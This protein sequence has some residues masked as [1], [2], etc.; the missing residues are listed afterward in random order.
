MRFY[1]DTRRDGAIACIVITIFCW[2]SL[3]IA[4][5]TVQH[6]PELM[7]ASGARY[8]PFYLFRD[9]D[10]QKVFVEEIDFSSSGAQSSGGAT[11]D[12]AVETT[13][14]ATSQSES[15]QPS[16]SSAINESARR[17]NAPTAPNSDVAST[18]SE[19]TQ[20][21]TVRTQRRSPISFDPRIRGY[22][23][24]QIYSQV[25]GAYWRPLRED[26]DTMLSK[27]PPAAVNSARVISG[28]YSTRYGPGFGFVDLTT[29]ETPRYEDGFES[30]LEL[31]TTYRTNGKR[32]YGYESVEAGNDVWGF[33]TIHGSR[34]GEEYDSGNDTEIA[35]DHKVQDIFTQF[36]Y[37]L[38]RYRRLE[39]Q[40]Q[41]LDQSDTEYFGKLFDIDFLETDAGSFRLINEKSDAAWDQS[42]VEG[43]FNYSRFKGHTDNPTK[44]STIDRIETALNTF[45]SVPAPGQS[46]AF[47]GDTFGDSLSTG[48]RNTM[49]Y[50]D[51]Q[52]NNKVLGY[53][54][55]YLSQKTVENFSTTAPN[56]F[57]P[58]VAMAGI[59]QF[60]TNL[61]RSDLFNL[62]IF[63]EMTH[64]IMDFWRIG[65]GARF[66]WVRTD[67]Q[68]S[69]VRPSTSL[70]GGAGGA[71]LQRDDFLYSFF[72][73]NSL[74]LTQTLRF[75]GNF[76]YAERPP[77]L[78][79]RYAD[80]LFL[81]LFQSGFSRVIGN[82]NLP[83]EKA[84]QL[85][86]EIRNDGEILQTGASWF[87]SWI[88][89]LSTYEILM[90]STPLG[91]S[92]VRGFTSDRAT[93]TGFEL[94]ANLV[95]SE[96]LDIFGSVVKLEGRDES[97]GAPLTGIS[98]L[99][100]R[101][102]FQLHDPVSN[103]WNVE[104]FGRLVAEQDELAVLEGS[105]D[106]VEAVTPEFAV[107]HFRGNLQATPNLRI[108][109]GVENLFDEN[110]LEHLDLRLPEDGGNSELAYLAPGFTPYIG[111]EW[112]R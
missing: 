107:W 49:I 84:W 29:S 67:A 100:G 39:L 62:G 6:P 81:G 59:D 30:H 61:P 75:D 101:I 26:L 14:V 33:R 64:E 89:D 69:D 28:P 18:I 90:P 56:A 98:P 106:P 55:R 19:S 1:D 77:T 109:G 31:G 86:F 51:V 68:E 105:T 27:I 47:Q 3:L 58:A 7:H 95:V 12:G 23:A 43:W 96:M 8:E 70:P 72:V 83:Q 5:D 93:L 66:D 24:G 52:G 11:T 10:L 99:E 44:D 32:F 91:A 40:Y 63:S 103:R 16:S 108:T 79:E 92:L 102:S 88:R 35:A 20:T 57:Q 45:F 71:D 73:T 21:E 110:Y 50:G 65:G 74:D 111:F 25:N 41:R 104:L 46:V 87:H 53:D 9:P 42:Y 17:F 13:S 76:G 78:T 94:N 2:C 48:F 37:N 54:L 112:R 15:S 22:R 4:Q 82:S 85:D 34:L 38:D 60:K 80:G 97:L 36:G